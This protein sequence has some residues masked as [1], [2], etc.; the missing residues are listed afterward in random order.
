MCK[1]GLRTDKKALHYDGMV[2]AEGELLSRGAGEIF[3]S[4]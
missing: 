3:L 2:K 4:S 1:E